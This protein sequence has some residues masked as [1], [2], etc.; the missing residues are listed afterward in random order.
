MFSVFMLTCLL[1]ENEGKTFPALVTSITSAACL[2]SSTVVVVFTTAT[3]FCSNTKAWIRGITVV[4]VISYDPNPCP[5]TCMIGIESFFV[6]VWLEGGIRNKGFP[7][8]ATHTCCSIFVVSDE[9]I[10]G[11]GFLWDLQPICGTS[12]L[13]SQAKC[14]KW[15]VGVGF[16]LCFLVVKATG[17][18]LC[19]VSCL[20]SPVFWTVSE[21]GLQKIFVD[22]IYF[23]KINVIRNWEPE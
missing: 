6:A 18:P 7:V 14:I 19:V 23:S 22:A 3:S 21:R 16:Q 12:G 1:T 15:K 11:G 8:V 4:L 9:G 2:V 20:V 5:G 10:Q 13:H 17:C